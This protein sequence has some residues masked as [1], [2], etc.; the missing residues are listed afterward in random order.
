MSIEYILRTQ[1]PVEAMQVTADNID[2]VHAWKC[3]DAPSSLFPVPTEWDIGL[4]YVLRNDVDY[5]DF[6]PMSDEEF[7]Q[8]Y[9]SKEAENNRLADAGMQVMLDRGW[10]CTFHEPHP[11]C[12]DCAFEHERTLTKMLAAFENV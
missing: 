1:P 7:Q 12:S 8:K 4:W 3:G 11:E 5:R 9:T 10:T 6:Y 2:E